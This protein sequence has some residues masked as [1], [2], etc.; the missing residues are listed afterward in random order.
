MKTNRK[1]FT[2]IELMV[3]I[4]IIIILAAIAIPNYINMTKR[5]QQ[6]K[7][8]SDAAVIAT[9]LEVYHTDYNEYP[10]SL[11]FDPATTNTTGL[12]VMGDDTSSVYDTTKVAY[13]TSAIVTQI[14]K[15]NTTVIY[16]LV[17]G[18]PDGWTLT[19]TTA[20]KQVGVR[21][22]LSSVMTWTQT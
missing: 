19:I 14:A 22:N 12:L 4:A 20:D 15:N 18:T 11:T 3:V 2:L 13:L 21:N 8:T 1:G 16:A 5:A 7:A 10:A 9:A 6:S 17:T